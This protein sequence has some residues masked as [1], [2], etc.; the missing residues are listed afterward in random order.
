M[1]DVI[2]SLYVYAAYVIYST[3][4]VPV[5]PDPL[6]IPTRCFERL[7]AVRMYSDT[8][9]ECFPSVTGEGGGGVLSGKKESKQTSPWRCRLNTNHRAPSTGPSILTT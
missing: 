4:T 1:C 5:A 7:L 8:A 3:C 2:S 9:Q 6:Y